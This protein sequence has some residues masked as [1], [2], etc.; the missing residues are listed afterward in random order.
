MAII[1]IKVSKLFKK[2]SRQCDQMNGIKEKWTIYIAGTPS[3]YAQI[4]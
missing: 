2:M 3:Q 4:R 1:I